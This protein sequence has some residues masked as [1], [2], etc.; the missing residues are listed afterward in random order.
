M[1]RVATG[2]VLSEA[3]MREILT[4]AAEE[5]LVLLA[6][7]VGDCLRATKGER[8]RWCCGAA[9]LLLLLSAGIIICVCDPVWFS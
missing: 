5:R 8:S 7:E 4:F 3:G 6:D 1:I 2:N 9:L